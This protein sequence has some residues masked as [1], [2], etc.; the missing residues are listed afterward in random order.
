[1]IL[2]RARAYT[3]EATLR[4]NWLA[5]VCPARRI[6]SGRAVSPDAVEANI[7]HGI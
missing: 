6:L 7:W 2:E 1:L 4:F 5:P 3:T